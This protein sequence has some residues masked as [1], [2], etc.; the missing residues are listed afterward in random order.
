[1]A[2]PFQTPLRQ[3]LNKAIAWLFERHI[4]VA[5]WLPWLRAKAD[6][7]RESADDLEKCVSLQSS[8]NYLEPLVDLRC[9]CWGSSIDQI[10][11][12]RLRFWWSV[13]RAF[14]RW[15]LTWIWRHHGAEPMICPWFVMV[16]LFCWAPILGN[17]VNRP[18]DNSIWGTAWE[19]NQTQWIPDAPA[20]DLQC[21]VG[22]CA[23]AHQTSAALA[24]TRGFLS[25]AWSWLVCPQR[26]QSW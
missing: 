13:R 15:S 18:K 5:S 2:K 1:M 22:C 9:R 20:G 25:L 11:L 19:L 24:V 4:P 26:G 23:G 16:L 6:C 7:T 3:G 8:L 10:V 21:H 14:F 12:T 17:L